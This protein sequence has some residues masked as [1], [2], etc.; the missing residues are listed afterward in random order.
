MRTYRRKAVL[1]TN[2][3]C[4]TCKR[5]LEY[6]NEV[7]PKANHLIKMHK[8]L[9]RL[10]RLRRPL[11]SNPAPLRC[12]FLAVAV[13]LRCY[14]SQLWDHPRLPNWSRHKGIRQEIEFQDQLIKLL[15]LLRADSRLA[16]KTASRQPS[17]PRQALHHSDSFLPRGNLLHYSHQLHGH[18]WPLQSFQPWVGREGRLFLSFHKILV[19]QVDLV[20]LSD[21]LLFYLSCHYSCVIIQIIA[22]FSEYTSF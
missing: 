18:Q 10:Q 22:L 17:R 14:G 5:H 1:S 9:L 19:S 13:Q 2:L 8:I 7:I 6:F 20:K 3:H 4:H 11:V 21:G 12:H 16:H 15:C